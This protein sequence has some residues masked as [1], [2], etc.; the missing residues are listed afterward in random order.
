LHADLGLGPD[1]RFL[2]WQLRLDT[3]PRQERA[4]LIRCY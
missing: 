3:A 4:Y 2:F 1:L